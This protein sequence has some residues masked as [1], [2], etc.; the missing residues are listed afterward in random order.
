[1]YTI[2]RFAALRVVLTCALVAGTPLRTSAQGTVNTAIDLARMTLE[3]LLH[4]RVTTASK[5]AESMLDA[6]AIMVV[7]TESDVHA[8]GNRSLVDVLDRTTSVFFMGTQ[9]NIQ[10]ALTMRGDATLGSNNHIL[11]LVNGRPIQESTHGGTIH[12]FLRAFPLASVKQIEVIRGPGSVLYGTNAYVGVINVITKDWD[13][14]GVADVSYGSFDTRMASVAGGRKIGHLQWSAGMTASHDDGWNFTAT[15]SL[16]GDKP[17]LTRTARWFDRKVGLN[18]NTKYKGLNVDLFYVKTQAPHLTNS[19]ATTSWTRYGISDAEQAMVDVGY[20]RALSPR[21]TSSLHGTYNHFTDVSDYGEIG[22]RDVRSDNYLV[23]WTNQLSITPALNAV[24]GANFSKRTGSFLEAAYDWYGVPSYNR[25]SVTAFGQADYR[26]VSRLKLIAGAQVIKIPGFT[27][28]VNG[29][30][31][32]DESTIP[33]I[34]PHVVG[35]LGAIVTLPRG[36]GVKLLHSEA[37]RQP[38]VVETDLVRYDE[39]DYSQEGNPDL[40]PEEIATTDLQL[41]YGSAHANAA[42][43]FFVSRQSNVIAETATSELIQNFDRFQTRGIE[44][45]ARVRFATHFELTS[46]VT[47]QKLDNTTNP[48]FQFF[49]IP[50]APFM[51]KVGLSYRTES[52][53]TLGVHDSYFGTPRESSY[54]DEEDPADTTKYVNPTASAFHDVRVNA[55]YRLGKPGF[56]GSR[57]DVTTHVSVSNLLDEQIYYAEYTSVNVNSIP[58]RPGRAVSAGVSIGW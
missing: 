26:P 30:Q 31:S 46:A 17:A 20:Q 52:G 40:R 3:E 1:M 56:L 55:S 53:L 7:L 45:E 36:F 49:A 12:P 10:G 21:W 19:T 11:V 51:A 28:H 18:F 2:A 54:F 24:F 16:D 34:A 8:Y 22:V 42:V 58:G 39:G 4:V 37:F 33:G 15:D 29:G 5:K 27:T 50:V 41:N 47:Y 13:S 32:A 44:G 57:A 23:D 35:R 9:E 48:I 14:S 25:N 43:T 6:P 38:S